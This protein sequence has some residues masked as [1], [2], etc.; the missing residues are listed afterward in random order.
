VRAALVALGPRTF[1]YLRSALLDPATPRHLRIHLPLTL[2]EFGTQEAADVL[3][4]FVQRGDDGLV[5]YRSLRALEQMVGENRVR[6]ATDEVRAVVRQELTE[7]FRLVAL[8]RALAPARAGAATPEDTRGVVL[9]L[10]DDKRDQ[11]VSRAFLLLKLCFPSED[12]RQVHA[13]IRSGDATTQGNVAEFLD[14][15]LAPRRRGRDDG[16]RALLRLVTEDL[17]DAERVARAGV[18]PPEAIPEGPDAAIALM[19]KDRDAMLAALA[20]SLAEEHVARGRAG[21]PVGERSQPM[22]D[23]ALLGALRPAGAHGR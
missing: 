7:Y 9:A 16:I 17:P 5:R 14:A 12:L 13:A 22:A 23:D 6:F 11:A 1:E 19:R 4:G 18:L 2:A 3:F 10:L 15:L 21:D 20:I 8:R